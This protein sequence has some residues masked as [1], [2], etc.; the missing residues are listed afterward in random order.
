MLELA[1]K[2]EMDLAESEDQNGFKGWMYFF[3]IS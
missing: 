3:L 2:P 1:E